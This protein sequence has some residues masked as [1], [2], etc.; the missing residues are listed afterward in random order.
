[1]ASI[2]KQVAEIDH[3]FSYD[4][5]EHLRHTLDLSEQEIAHLIH[6]AP[7]T[8]T[9]RKHGAVFT[10][11][12]SERIYRLERILSLACILFDND[13]DGAVKWLK[14]PNRALGERTPLEFSRF[15]VGAREVE[16]LIGRIEHG[17][18]S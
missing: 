11:V 7:R 18:F 9:R 6:I 13:D 8:L 4:R 14:T 16:N 12:E 3:G 5:F 15:E 17:V 1:M 10:A 2:L